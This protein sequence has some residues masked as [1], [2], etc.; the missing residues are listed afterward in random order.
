MVCL[1]AGQ[2]LLR[3]SVS[4]DR[5][6]SNTGSGGYCS[7]GISSVCHAGISTV[8]GVTSSQRRCSV[9]GTSVNRWGR[10]TADS[11]ARSKTHYFIQQSLFYIGFCT[12]PGEPCLQMSLKARVAN[13]L[14]QHAWARFHPVGTLQLIGKHR[15]PLWPR[16]LWLPL[17]QYCSLGRMQNHHRAGGM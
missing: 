17:L 14:V 12:S 5:R 8:R 6:P 1:E 13:P 7:I 9:V 3:P 15:W 2:T 11:E 4:A 16:Y 10:P